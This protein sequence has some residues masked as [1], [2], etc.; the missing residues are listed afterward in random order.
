M[1]TKSKENI[2]VKR[3]ETM[4]SKVRRLELVN[5]NMRDLLDHVVPLAQ[6]AIQEILSKQRDRLELEKRIGIIKNNKAQ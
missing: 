4:E 3:L 2:Y 5:R 6:W 1:T